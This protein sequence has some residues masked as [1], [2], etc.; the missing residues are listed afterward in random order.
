[1]PTDDRTEHSPSDPQWRW[2][3]A[4]TDIRT[5]PTPEQCDEIRR[6][7]Q[8]HNASLTGTVETAIARPPD[9]AAVLAYSF[10]NPA[11]WRAFMNRML[12]LEARVATLEAK[13]K[14]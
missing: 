12:A 4:N 10:A 13:L 6:T 9:E 7:A 11:Q 1:M 3:G 8:S 14:A 2:R 5:R